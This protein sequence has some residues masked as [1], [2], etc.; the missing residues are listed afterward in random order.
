MKNYFKEERSQI[1]LLILSYMKDQ[2]I[3]KRMYYFTN[4]LVKSCQLQG[5]DLIAFDDM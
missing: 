1:L 2:L 5:S 4:A 3:V